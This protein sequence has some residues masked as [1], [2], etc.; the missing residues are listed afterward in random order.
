[1]VSW[2][3]IWGRIYRG[4]GHPAKATARTR[5]LDAEQGPLQQLQ[6]TARHCKTLHHIATR[7]N[8]L[9]HTHMH[10]RMLSRGNRRLEQGLEYVGKKISHGIELGDGLFV[11]V[12]EAR[13]LHRRV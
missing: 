10:L 11:D 12:V 7:C 6:D 3:R 5:A 4:V 8:T 9:L 13:H 1:M 2:V